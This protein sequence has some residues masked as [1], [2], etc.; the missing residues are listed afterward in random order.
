MTE[1]W[2]RRAI[3][4][5]AAAGA[6]LAVA[7]P[8]RAARRY[9]ALEAVLDGY[10]RARRLPGAIVAVVRPGRF[11]PDYVSVGTTDFDHAQPMRPDTL[12]R[13]FSMTKP[14][15]GMAVMQAV[16]EGRIGIDTPIAQVLPAF[17]APRVLRAGAPTLDAA[18]PATRPIRVRHLLTHSAGFSYHIL[19]DGVLEREYRRQGLLPVGGAGRLAARPGDPPP[20]ALPEFLERLARLPLLFEPG[21]AWRYSVGLDV[22]G[23]LLERLDG[24]TLDRVFERRL[25]G[26]LG[27][28]DTGFHIAQGREARLA[29][30]WSYQDPKTEGWR[31]E[32]LRVDGPEASDWA[33]PPTLLAGGA[34][35]VSTA[36]DYARF[37]QMLLNEGEFEGRR[38]LAPG[39]ARL[40]M[41]NL[42]EPGVFPPPARDVPPQGHGA[43]GAVTLFETR[44]LMR[45]GTPAGVFG[46]GGA[47]GTL[48]SVDPVRRVGVVTMVQYVPASRFP[49]GIDM[50]IA[51]N[52]EE[53]AGRL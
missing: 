17:S 26:P 41:G 3:L 28:R 24:A 37:V 35:L 14:V 39:L 32:P 18:T 34:G 50:A 7:G 2:A 33:A 22:A 38:L 16:G 47:A 20:V 1:A 49:L 5:A 36:A 40:A 27:M 51:L 44:G 29:A 23:G 9:A 43:G 48:F 15:T 53:Q 31:D 11:R 25:L 21:T 46:W 52:R 10:V 4:K 12:V 6:A 30:L 19:G 42:L 8:V 45:S 13:I